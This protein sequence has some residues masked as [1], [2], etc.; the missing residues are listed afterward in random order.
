MVNV[1]VSFDEN[2][3]FSSSDPFRW[4]ISISLYSATPL[5]SLSDLV[6]PRRGLEKRLVTRRY[7]GHF[8]IEVRIANKMKVRTNV[9][10]TNVAMVGSKGSRCGGMLNRDAVVVNGT[11]NCLIQRYASKLSM[12]RIHWLTNAAIVNAFT[13]SALCCWCEATILLSSC[14]RSSNWN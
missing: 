14:N 10:P 3:W 11:N 4:P 8:R 7:H 1:S 2:I 5:N 9:I 12:L 6:T 13:C